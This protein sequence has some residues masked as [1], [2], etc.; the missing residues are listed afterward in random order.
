[1]DIYYWRIRVYN[2]TMEYSKNN[3]PTFEKSI[4]YNFINSS[5]IQNSNNYSNTIIDVVKEDTLDTYLVYK[6]L[7][8]NPVLLNL[9]DPSIPGG[10]VNMGASAQEENIFR[11]TNYFL[12]LTMDF[13]P[14]LNKDSVYSTGV[15][16]FRHNEN[17]NY[18]FMENHVDVS[19]IACPSVRHPELTK[20]FS[21]FKN[22]SDKLLMYKKICMIF[23]IA[24]H[25]GHDTVIL[26]ALGCGAFKCPAEQVAKLFRVAIE[27]YKK[28]F[29]YIV[30]AIKQPV[31]AQSKNNYEIFRNILV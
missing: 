12:T 30:F 26:S 17:D 9:A 23:K 14:L 21:D 28:Y 2:E 25:N 13:Y 18:K 29:K 22:K 4:K 8:H 1:M 5:E 11:R 16:L 3:Y 24:A 31:D 10:C 6:K 7:G 19:I 15:K 27:K 20:D